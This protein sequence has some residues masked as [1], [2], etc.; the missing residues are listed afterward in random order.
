[1]PFELLADIDFH[2]TDSRCLCENERL[3][4]YTRLGHP[5]PFSLSVATGRFH[6]FHFIN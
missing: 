5:V 2:T 6:H 4:G 1:M 3:Q